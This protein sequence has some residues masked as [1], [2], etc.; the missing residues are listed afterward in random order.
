MKR[1]ERWG[2][3]VSDRGTE[4]R[5][6]SRRTRIA[7]S[8]LSDECPVPPSLEGWWLTRRVSVSDARSQPG[9]TRVEPGVMGPLSA[10][11]PSLPA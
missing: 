2:E 3:H 1:L 7:A 5:Q 8:R 9:K 6:A 4:R 11:E 10:G